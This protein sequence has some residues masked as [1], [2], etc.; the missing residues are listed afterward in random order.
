MLA[1][2]K[3]SLIRDGT[4]PKREPNEFGIAGRST[5]LGAT[6]ESMKGYHTHI[7]HTNKEV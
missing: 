4:L 3:R 6:K 7:V 5:Y 1:E 2:T